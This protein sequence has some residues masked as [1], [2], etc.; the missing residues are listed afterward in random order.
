MTIR[1]SRIM[2]ALLAVAAVIATVVAIPIATGGSAHEDESHTNP[3]PLGAKVP[4]ASGSFNG[5]DWS[6]VLYRSDRGL[7]YEQG[8]SGAAVAV[9]ATCG[10][11]PRGRAVSAVI[12]RFGPGGGATGQFVYGAV[13]PGVA[14]VDVVL[15]SGAVLTAR[16]VEAPSAVG[17]RNGFYV[18]GAPAAAVQVVRARDRGGKVV[19]A[20]APTPAPTSSASVPA[21]T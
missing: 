17:S 19:D 2:L 11:I 6:L 14:S 10:A 1:R 9:S 12:D 18:V 16:P 5:I 21:H 15:G 20:Y 4:V 13:R 8:Y 3:Q 7:C